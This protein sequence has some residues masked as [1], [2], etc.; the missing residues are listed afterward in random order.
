MEFTA[1]FALIF[2]VAFFIHRFD[3]YE[4]SCALCKIIENPKQKNPNGAE[5]VKGFLSSILFP[6]SMRFFLRFFKW[7]TIFLLKHFERNQF[8][9]S[10]DSQW[11]H[12][13][14]K[15]IA[16]TLWMICTHAH[17]KCNVLSNIIHTDK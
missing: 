1:E 17:I 14:S 15:V 11:I 12:R 8:F 10:D 6:Y 16:R 13:V 3:V 7:L 5:H 9:L 2:S 4:S